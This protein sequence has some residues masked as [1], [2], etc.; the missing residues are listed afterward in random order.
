MEQALNQIRVNKERM[1]TNRIYKCDNR[2]EDQGK[3]PTEAG[4]FIPVS[5][6]TVGGANV[7]QSVVFTGGMC[8]E[9]ITFSYAI[10]GN[11]NDIGDVIVTVD[12]ENPKSLFCKDWFMF[13]NAELYHIET[14]FFRGK[15]EVTFKSL[16]PEQKTVI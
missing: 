1:S 11:E 16:N 4:Y 7:D 15:H 12:T 2:F 10:T 3:D 9:K 13:G 14:F 6:G 5:V 8:F